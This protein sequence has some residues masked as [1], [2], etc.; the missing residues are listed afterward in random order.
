ML[1][2]VTYIF[3]EISCLFFSA[4][5]N[6][7]LFQQYESQWKQYEVQMEQRKADI[8]TRKEKVLKSVA[9]STGP[10][11][12]SKQGRTSEICVFSLLMNCEKWLM[13]KQGQKSGQ[14]ILKRYLLCVSFY[15]MIDSLGTARFP[16]SIMLATFI[17]VIFLSTP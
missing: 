3:E 6:K 17:S 1:T 15:F 5:P 2:F 4:H 9:S 10:D 7:E 13:S 12:S 8:K 11:S 14:R 16:P